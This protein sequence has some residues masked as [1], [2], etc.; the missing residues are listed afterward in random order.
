MPFEYACFIS[1]RH[2]QRKLVQRIVNDLYDAL[3]SELEAQ[4][5]R[6][7]VY[8]DRDRLQGG[9]FYNEALATALCQSV[10]M[11]VVFTPA[12][13][14]HE[15]TYCTR[16]YKAMERLETERLRL[17]PPAYRKHGLIIPIVFRGE[18]YFPQELKESRQYHN[19]G[20]FLLCD[21]EIWRHPHYASKIKEIADYIADRCSEFRAL[22][23]QDD[24]CSCC[25]EFTLPTEEEISPWLETIIG[26]EIPKIPFPRREES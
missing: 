26:S 11:I 21:P 16:E 20:D 24:P 8:L 9:D 19:F 6:D 2:G 14:D 4:F 1:Y 18:K 3:C 13:F 22:A 25:E 7:A 17:L 10:C 5:G 12:Y 23:R 15:H